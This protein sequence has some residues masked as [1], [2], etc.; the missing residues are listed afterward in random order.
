MN[1]A[2]A[3]V[4]FLPIAA[5]NAE[6]G[7]PWTALRVFNSGRIEMTQDIASEHVCRETLC[8]AQYGMSC[9]DHVDAEKQAKIKAQL[10]ELERKKAELVY[11]E[12]HPCEVN[13]DGTKTCKTSYCESETYDKDGKRLSGASSC[14]SIGTTYATNPDSIRVAACFQ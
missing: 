12:S 3:L 4:F 7:K 8:Y 14:F 1:I 6:D 13:K 9:T 5:A 11:R 2:L 10:V